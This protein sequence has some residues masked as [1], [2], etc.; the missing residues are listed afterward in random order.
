MGSRVV[1][2]YVLLA[3]AATAAWPA[4]CPANGAPLPTAAERQ[5]MVPIA[6]LRCFLPETE[7]RVIIG[8]IGHDPQATL[9]DPAYD[10]G[11]QN[12]DGSLNAGH[13]FSVNVTNGNTPVDHNALAAF[14]H[15][16]AHDG[17]FLA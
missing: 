12:P 4:S 5:V 11:K 6:I 16:H 13:T 10:A 15:A 7:V 8:S 1:A 2:L 9:T 3:L 14:A 17:F